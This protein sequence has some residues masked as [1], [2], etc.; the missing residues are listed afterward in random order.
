M[1]RSGY[2]WRWAYRK[3]ISYHVSRKKAFYL[4]T[5]YWITGDT[6]RFR[7]HGGFRMSRLRK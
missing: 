6:G 4:A 2:G 7:S 5:R 3:L 1:S